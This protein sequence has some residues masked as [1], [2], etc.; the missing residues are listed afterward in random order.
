MR[1]FDVLT[2]VAVNMNMLHGYPAAVWHLSCSHQ[3][4]QIP[5]PPLKGCKSGQARFTFN[6]SSASIHPS[7]VPWS[8]LVQAWEATRTHMQN[9]ATSC[10]ALY[11]T[12]YQGWSEINV[13][14]D[15]DTLRLE[16]PY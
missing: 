3:H 6:V 15:V 13:V 12:L 2:Q 14:I 10:C 9:I 7:G 8:L 5:A 1:R 16:L 11:G 4:T